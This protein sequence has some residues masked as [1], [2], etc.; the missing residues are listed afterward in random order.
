MVM[1][2]R[3]W[4]LSLL[5]NDLLFLPIDLALHLQLLTVYVELFLG[6]AMAVTEGWFL[7]FQM[8]N[9]FS[10]FLF[11]HSAQLL[12]HV[13]P[14]MLICRLGHREQKD[15]WNPRRVDVFQKHNVVPPSSVISAGSVNSAC[16]AGICKLSLKLRGII[17]CTA[18]PV[19]NLDHFR[20]LW[21]DA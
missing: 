20:S 9:V 12:V 6:G 17:M 15:E 16:T 7:L 10:I 2:T 4:L 8:V 11:L 18:C 21:D 1:F 5:I 19:L 14:W 13:T 3:K